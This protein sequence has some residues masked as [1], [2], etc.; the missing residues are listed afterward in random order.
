MRTHII[1]LSNQMK[2]LQKTWRPIFCTLKYC[3]LALKK[4]LYS[5]HIE[6]EF[7]RQ[8]FHSYKA[9]KILPIETFSVIFKSRAVIF[10]PLPQEF[11]G[12]CPVVL[13]RNEENLPLKWLITQKLTVWSNVYDFCQSQQKSLM[14]LWE[15]SMKSILVRISP[16]KSISFLKCVTSFAKRAAKSDVTLERSIECRNAWK[17][18]QEIKSLEKLRIKRNK[19]NNGVEWIKSW[20]ITNLVSHK[21]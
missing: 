8:K 6:F 7:S 21:N 9:S 4:C 16:Y 10:C 3:T 15:S 17:K 18:N 14:R 13:S 5:I 19:W 1:H 20:T 2:I 12:I 11:A